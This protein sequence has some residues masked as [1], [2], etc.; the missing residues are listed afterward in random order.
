M[1]NNWLKI[2]LY[3]IKNNKFFTALNVLG[4][5]MGIAGLIFAILYW[6]DEHSYNAWN[7][8]KERIFYSV[9][10]LGE[11]KVW[12][13]SAAPVGSYMASI[14]EVTEYCYM[15]AWYTSAVMQYKG[16][17]EIIEKVTD[18]QKNFFSFFPF[19]FTMGNPATALQE[20][21]VVLSEKTAK[22]LFGNDNP[23]GE[24][25]QSG[26]KSFTVKG[27]YK[28]NGKS[29]FE[30]DLVTCEINPK[31]KEKESRWGS[32]SFAM[33]VKLK[34]PAKAAT[35]QDKIEGL[36]YDY[37][38]KR[39]AVESGISTKEYVDRYGKTKI[40]LESLKDLR[41]HSRVSDVPEGRGNYQFLLIMLG[42]S[43]LILLL[44]I[45]NY[46]NLATANAIKRAKEVGVRKILGASKANI[47]KQFVFETVLTT[48]FSMLLAM[49]IVEI[50]LPYYNMFLGK[51]L[52]I[53]GSQFHIQLVAVFIVIVALSGIMP[54]IYVSK[55]ESVN[56]LKGNF[57]RSKKGIWLRNGMLVFQFSIASFFIVGSYIVNEQVNYLGSKD[58]GFKG[59]QIIDINY[60][61]PYDFTVDN[62]DKILARKYVSVKERLLAIKGVEQVSGGTF[63]IGG[64]SSQQTTFTFGGKEV[65]LQ[66]MIVD[67][68][69]LDLMKIKIAKGRD[70]SPNFASDT[71]NSVLLNETAVKM[72]NQK[73]PVGKY[74][75]YW[76]DKKFKIIGIV[77]DFHLNNPQ[78]P[79]PPMIFSH[80]KTMNWMIQNTNNIYVKV[81]PKYMQS[82]IAEM[83]ELW[84]TVD[85][86]Y[87]FSYDFVDKNFARS[88]QNFVRQRNLFSLLNIAVIMI[89]LFGLFALAS[90]SIQRRM[91]EIAIRK[92]LGADTS[93]LLKELSKQYIIFCVVGF[94][95]ALFPVY[96]L[97][98]KW[99]DNFSYRINISAL[100]FIIGFVILMALTL[101]V[102]LGRAYRA[103]RVNVLKYLKYE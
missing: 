25:I 21:T 65:S 33:L 60:R 5:A 56:V 31:L 32:F 72:F 43:L 3:Q 59:D 97:L 99:L 100:P 70:L 58:L 50:S 51:E 91:K 68:D 57:S 14:P 62:F 88:Y 63:R 77:K 29:S 89:A 40:Y 7:P 64:G 49:V 17:K 44:S 19:E 39:S 94:L 84:R 12:G 92:T 61:N 27:V 73:D 46:I 93:V 37:G 52:V 81:N 9:A 11:N 47:V 96:I 74:V 102:V 24:V 76:D 66:Y 103:T 82:A 26:D 101:I 83:E 41:L 90:Y 30:P 16:K 36:Y 80:Y 79:I 87:P 38:T 54:A 18:A 86:D 85:P 42:L 13:A 8:D 20:G 45:V 71:I 23:M 35:V 55:F 78:D 75:T 2:F 22:R 10:D 28:L 69:L 15:N 6:N 4:L 67:F 95:I 48:L 34:D 53:K 1:I 98:D